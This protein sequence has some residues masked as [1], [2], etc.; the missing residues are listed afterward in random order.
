[1][2]ALYCRIKAGQ[3]GGGKSE[4]K[5]LLNYLLVPESMLFYPVC[6]LLP[7]HAPSCGGYSQWHRDARSLFSLS[8]M[9]DNIIRVVP[10]I[11]F[12]LHSAAVRGYRLH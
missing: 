1:M 7:N 11:F 2:Q 3:G 12:G 4:I 10:S 9:R 6:D 8:P 5:Q